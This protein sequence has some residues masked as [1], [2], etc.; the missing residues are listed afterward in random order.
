M[1]QSK[2][3]SRFKQLF[4]DHESGYMERLKK[5]SPPCL[6]FIGKH[7]EL[8][9]KKHECN[10][11]N[12]ENHRKQ[13]WNEQR[14]KMEKLK[15]STTPTTPTEELEEEAAAAGN[16]SLVNFSKYRLLIDFVSNLLQYQNVSYRFRINERI[17]SFIL[18]DIENYIEEA[19]RSS[20][21]AYDDAAAL[22]MSP[23]SIQDTIEAWL[24]EKSKQIEPFDV[25]KYPK[26]RTY[27][28]K[29]PP[30]SFDS[31]SIP[32][33]SIMKGSANNKNLAHLKR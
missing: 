19:K 6:P 26:I 31:A 10:K 32:L 14:V 21:K 4:D 16:P 22:G 5:C 9:F 15:G 33:E 27:P 29:S 1:E 20:S 18:D 28:L 17:R 3:Y 11:L 30:P 8:V 2:I 24:H 12:S 25:Y 7:L 13:I 23:P